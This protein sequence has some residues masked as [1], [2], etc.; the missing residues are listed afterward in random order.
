MFYEL[1]RRPTLTKLKLQGCPVGRDEARLLSSKPKDSSSNRLAKLVPTSYHNTSIKMLDMSSNQLV[2]I[3][4]ARLLRDILCSN[5]TMTALNLPW[6][7][8][9]NST[10]AVERFADGLGRCIADGLGSNSML[11]KIDLSRCDLVDCGVSILAHTLGSRNA[12]LQK[13]TVVNNSI[14]ST[15]VGVLLEAMV[16]SSH[17]ITISTSSATLLGTREQIS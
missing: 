17:C 5:K 1:A 15:G 14:T 11:P 13:L 6:N 10:G 7:T 9:A 3:T 2:S 8:F 16:R 12:R 4:C